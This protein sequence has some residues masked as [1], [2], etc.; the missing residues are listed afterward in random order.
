MGWGM[1]S[2]IRSLNIPNAVSGLLFALFLPASLMAGWSFSDIALQYGAGLALLIPL[3]FLYAGG[4]IGGGDLK[5]F[6]ATSVWIGWRALPGYLLA[7]VLIGGG[8]ALIVLILRKMPE[9]PYLRRLPWLRPST[10]PTQGIPY[11]VAIALAAIILFPHL[12]I[13]LT[14]EVALA[15]LL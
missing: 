7:V 12:D 10:G 15:R 9:L 11:G 14:G 8:L 2:D 13:T 1:V 5:L 4:F 6:V 3:I